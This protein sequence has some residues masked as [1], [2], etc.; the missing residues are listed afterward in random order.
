MD[1]IQKMHFNAIL[2]HK[3]SS[4]NKTIQ[5]LYQGSMQLWK[6]WTARFF[7]G[8]RKGVVRFFVVLL[9]GF[10][11][12]TDMGPNGWTLSGPRAVTQCQCKEIYD[13]KNAFLF[14]G[15]WF[16]WSGLFDAKPGLVTSLNCVL[17]RQLTRDVIITSGQ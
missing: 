6:L 14:Q 17:P 13:G 3:Q 4:D 2:W 10:T 8:P 5:F 12:K 9:R 15:I 7:L 16:H 1:F 11:R